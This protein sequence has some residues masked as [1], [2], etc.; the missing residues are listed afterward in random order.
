[1][2]RKQNYLTVDKECQAIKRELEALKHILIGRHLHLFS[3]QGCGKRDN[4]SA[5]PR[6]LVRFTP[7]S[8]APP[9][10]PECLYPGTAAVEAM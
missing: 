4:P 10:F 5:I 2:P 3:E 1:M 9:L 6:I 8:A 7:I